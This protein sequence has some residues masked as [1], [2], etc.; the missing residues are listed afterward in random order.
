VD[1]RQ[2]VTKV[3]N[4]ALRFFPNPRQVRLADRKLLEGTA[5][6]GTDEE[7]REVQSERSLSATE[8]AELRRK[9]NVRHVWVPAEEGLLRAIEVETGLSDSQHTELLRGEIRPGDRLVI[10]LQVPGLA[11]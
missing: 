5:Q 10:G 9:R 7:G 2:T 6:S 4:A 1:E 3:P 8:R 11:G